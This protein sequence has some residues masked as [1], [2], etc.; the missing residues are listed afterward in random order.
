[1][2]GKMLIAVTLLSL[3]SQL[4]AHDVKKEVFSN[5]KFSC[6]VIDSRGVA[7][8]MK[9]TLSLSGAVANH[10]L[11][12]GLSAFLVE[13]TPPNDQAPPA[14]ESLAQATLVN[15]TPIYASNTFIGSTN[16][17]HNGSATNFKLGS[18]I[19]LP[20]DATPLT[21]VPDATF[22]ND[23]RFGAYQLISY[24]A[25]STGDFRLGEMS[26]SAKLNLKEVGAGQYVL[27]SDIA[28]TGALTGF[29]PQ[30]EVATPLGASVLH[31]DGTCTSI[32]L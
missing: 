4:M 30:D 21:E 11:S 2:K 16:E 6:A 31:L 5:K 32:A 27:S 19:T 20:K 7:T 13:Q 25:K 1:M 28:Y 17:T 9:L 14:A 26:F 29:N 10:A 8:S 3:S 12:Q 24:K 22:V 15:F 23:L 18:A